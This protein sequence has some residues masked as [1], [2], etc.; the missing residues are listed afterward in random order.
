[1]KL[2]TRLAIVVTGVLT[3]ISIIAGTQSILVN[4]NEKLATY[5]SALNNLSTQLSTT[6]EDPVSLALFAAENSPIPM[7]LVFI[8][9][10]SAMSYLS[11]DAGSNLPIPNKSTYQ[12]GLVKPIEIDNYLVRYFEINESEY[13]AFFLSTETVNQE[14]GRTYIP[15]ITFNFLLIILGGV[16]VAYIFRR[17]SKLNSEAKAIQ[18]FIGDASHELKTPLTIIRGY[19]ELL[20]KDPAS[21][22]KYAERINIES[23]RM[24][25][26]IDNLLKIAELDELGQQEAISIDLVEYIESQIEDLL[27]LQPKRN[28]KLI[29]QPSTITAS[30]E[31]VDTL[32]SNIISNARIHTPDSAPIQITVIG[33]QVII[34]D[35]GSGL[36]SIPNKPFQR[37]DKSRSR[38]TGGSGLGMS[39]IQ[40][41]AK[42]LGA[43]L[44]FGK[45][46]L[47]GLKVEINF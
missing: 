33:K 19:S 29:A 39:L 34:E 12:Q 7:S 21:V 22:Q 5:N 1:M 37:F 23:L 44:D 11:E 42:K 36:N 30:L 41:S 16:F 15:I 8:T 2:T 6:A 32:I 46:E 47:G 9:N 10:N 28:V 18:E 38:E 31:L 35:G 17:D 27:L 13:L 43:K 3:V 40:K 25:S 45:S 4:R 20:A 24:T 26:L 14:L